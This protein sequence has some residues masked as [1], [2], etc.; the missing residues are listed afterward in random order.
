MNMTDSD[1]VYPAP[2]G[3]HPAHIFSG[4]T[5]AEPRTAVDASDV[6]AAGNVTIWDHGPP[7]EETAAHDEWHKTHGDHPIAAVMDAQSARHALAVDPARYALDPLGDD[8]EVAAEVEA[9]KRRREEALKASAD[10]LAKAQLAADRKTAMTTVMA[11]RRVKETAAKIAAKYPPLPVDKPLVTPAKA[12]PVPA[13]DAPPPT[14]PNTTPPP[15]PSTW[16]SP[17]PADAV[18]GTFSVHKEKK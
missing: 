7:Q 12:P 4:P 15:G 14:P 9:I 2:D 1:P 5:Q 6:D 8:S 16:A 3:P 18:T 13:W 10:H 17:P 11:R